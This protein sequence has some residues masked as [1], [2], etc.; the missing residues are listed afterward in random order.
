MKNYIM[1]WEIDLYYYFIQNTGMC[2]IL[3]TCKCPDMLKFI[4]KFC[5]TP[6]ITFCIL[7][8]LLYT[9]K[10]W[11]YTGNSPKCCLYEMKH[12]DHILEPVCQQIKL[13]MN[14]I[15]LP[16]RGVVWEKAVFT[17]CNLQQNVERDAALLAVRKLLIREERG[18]M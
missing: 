10:V 5:T 4:L 8:N 14:I 17:K 7:Q 18:I 16:K 1:K 12:R 3:L 11:F 9:A 13:S 2:S 15:Y 6:T